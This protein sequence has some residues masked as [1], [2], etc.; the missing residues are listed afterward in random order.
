MPDFLNS[1]MPW[2]HQEE[3]R[4]RSWGRMSLTAA[5]NVSDLLEQEWSFD[6]RENFSHTVAIYEL[7]AGAQSAGIDQI[8]G[9][10]SLFPSDTASQQL[11]IQ[12]FLRQYGMRVVSLKTDLSAQS[13]SL[14]RNA[15]I[16][17]VRVDVDEGHRIYQ[18]SEPIEPNRVERRDLGAISA[19]TVL[20]NRNGE[21]TVV[22][23]FDDDQFYVA[24]SGVDL[25]GEVAA[26]IAPL[27]SYD[28][29]VL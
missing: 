26:Q 20:L 24:N 2:K 21:A 27:W 25:I 14:L 19:V 3:R 10:A 11:E 22:N 17:S 23:L 16:D 13:L 7:S 6:S 18:F 15:R 28:A 29:N 12:A 5:P 8:V 1:Y 4:E 9:V